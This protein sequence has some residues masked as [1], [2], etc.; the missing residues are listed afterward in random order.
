[1]LETKLQ[2]FLDRALA[3]HLLF[4][5]R[6]AQKKSLKNNSKKQRKELP[7]ERRLLSFLIVYTKASKKLEIASNDVCEHILQKKE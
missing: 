1:M 3:F 7:I 2:K 6:N 5:S 4:I